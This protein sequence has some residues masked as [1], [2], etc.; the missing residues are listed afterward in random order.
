MNRRKRQQHALRLVTICLLGRAFNVAAQQPPAGLAPPD[1]AR[2]ARE[3]RSLVLERRFLGA[4]GWKFHYSLTDMPSDIREVAFLVVGRSAVGPGEPFNQTDV[5][6]FDSS[7]QHLYTAA[8]AQ[9]IV[10]VWHHGSLTGLATSA[11]VYDRIERDGCRYEFQKLYA[12]VPLETELK[13]ILARKDAPGAVC[14]YV[15]PGGF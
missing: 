12:V 10:V 3:P 8:T 1:A 2:S 14:K 4:S 5:L 13:S 7:T 6:A 15:A 11:L 9:F